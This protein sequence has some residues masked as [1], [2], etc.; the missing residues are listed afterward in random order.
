M[1]IAGTAADS[2]T[3]EQR[4]R[5]SEVLQEYLSA[6][7]DADE[8][9]PLEAN[10]KLDEKRAE[11]IDGELKPLL[12]GYLEGRVPLAEFKSKA[13]SINKRHE[14]WGFKGIKGQMFFNMVVNV[15]DDMAECDEE[16]K[17]AL[18]PPANEDIARRRIKTFVRYVKRIGEQHL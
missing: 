16:L 8:G 9:T 6:P 18:A 3:A 14:Y 11:I 15:A 5:S 7:K 1:S 10:V 12:E 17:A 2:L 4:Q 13:D